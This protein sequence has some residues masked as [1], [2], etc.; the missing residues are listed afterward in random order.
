MPIS[1]RDEFPVYGP[2]P[3]QLQ[4]PLLGEEQSYRSYIGVLV[5]AHSIVQT[6]LRVVEKDKCCIGRF[7]VPMM[8][9]EASTAIQGRYVGE[10]CQERF[11]DKVAKSDEAF[12]KLRSR[13]YCFWEHL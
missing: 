4:T 6:L 13:L 2:R 3:L 5:V 10:I 9:L 7:V 1:R 11:V 12:K 8:L